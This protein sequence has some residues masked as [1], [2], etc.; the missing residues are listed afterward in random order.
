[1]ARV[2]LFSS[3]PHNEK[4]RR[5]ST[6]A[7]TSLTDD[8]NNN[9][10]T[11][12]HT[13]SN[14]NELSR[15]AQ[16]N[17]G[18]PPTL[19]EDSH[20]LD[21]TAVPSPNTTSSAV[22]TSSSIHHPS[23][24]DNNRDTIMK[25]D[26]SQPEPSLAHSLAQSRPVNL[27]INSLQQ[28]TTTDMELVNAFA[29][30]LSGK[31]ENFQM[32]WDKVRRGSTS[33]NGQIGG[34]ST[35]DNGQQQ[36][37]EGGLKG[38]DDQRPGNDTADIM[39]QEAA[40]TALQLLGLASSS[41]PTSANDKQGNSDTDKG[42]STDSNSTIPEGHDDDA[43]NATA[44]AAAAVLRQALG[45]QQQPHHHHMQAQTPNNNNNI[46][47]ALNAS[48]LIGNYP[49]LTSPGGEGMDIQEEI[50][51][52]YKRGTWTRE[53]D[54][55][56]LLGIKRF[57]YGR[58]KEIASTIPG[59]KG[60]QLK[61]RW[62]NTL[63]SKY[64]D[65]ELLQ[66]KL[67]NDDH[68]TKLQQHL[69]GLAS[70]SNLSAPPP[71]PP[72]STPTNN[73]TP[74]LNKSLP[75]MHRVEPA[76]WTEIAH[77][78]T[79]KVRE[80]DQEAIEAL[81]SQAL[82]GTGHPMESTSTSSPQQSQSQQSQQSSTLSLSSSSS[83]SSSST[84]HIKQEE[85]DNS[86]NTNTTSLP[87]PKTANEAASIP[88]VSTESTST[89]QSPPTISPALDTVNYSRSVTPTANP[90]S[91]SSSSP[92]P[93][94][95]ATSTNNA[96]SSTSIQQHNPPVLNYADAAALSLYQQLSQHHAATTTSDA[97]SNGTNNPL[98]TIQALANNQYFL[99]NLFANVENGGNDATGAALAAAAAAAA[100]AMAHATS[101]SGPNPST[102][103]ADA[104]SLLASTMRSHLN[105]DNNNNSGGP[106]GPGDSSNNKNNKDHMQD[107]RNRDASGDGTTM[108]QQHK[109]R[110]SDPA[111][112]NTQSEAMSIYAS[113]SPVTTMVNNQP[114][115]VYPCLF[116]NCG[117]A[118][119]RL[120]NLKSHSRT[121]TDDRPF[122]CQL[123]NT[124]FSRNHDLKRHLKTHVGEKPYKC[125]GCQKTF[126]RLDALK[127]HKS[128]A[129]N[130]AICLDT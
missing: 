48:M 24:N 15:L 102:T 21:I 16:L 75:T 51:Q 81:L 25:D 30:A 43:A 101:N 3:Q 1:M 70:A 14:I 63:A 92:S 59:R 128:N 108:N 57:G 126:S 117:K 39:D 33:G 85:H 98:A 29:A 91:S 124:A 118:F 53:E 100:A 42:K 17:R 2:H 129:R 22:S 65:A 71:P 106:L 38:K 73:L 72:L 67:R 5:I 105:A 87:T 104:S 109:R 9:N 20:A 93:S 120:Y 130:Q 56:L 44:A 78:I 94:V 121:H 74:P 6:T 50:L 90:S 23:T 52:D 40:A 10:T 127:R 113:S 107:N 110:R 12:K 125:G 96:P 103:T 61:Q 32:I 66:N 116:P 62:D 4:R 19:P 58:W 68:I 99:S 79:E 11:N 45:H 13:H 37:H 111:L 36:Q 31:F 97:D 123:C 119:A 54:D 28:N 86:Q 88:Q 8:N 64:V 115:T 77:K 35:D 122:C 27:P 41:S 34:D 83:S 49:G 80:G 7:S 112:A 46:N 47:S 60:K 89:Q 26:T 95:S 69:E 84:S 18:P 114:Q 55:L 82:L 76:D